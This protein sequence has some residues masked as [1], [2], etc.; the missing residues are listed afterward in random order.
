V[1]ICCAFAESKAIAPTATPN[2]A[3]M[4]SPIGVSVPCPTAVAEDPMA[5]DAPPLTLIQ[6][7]E[8]GNGGPALYYECRRCGAHIVIG[9]EIN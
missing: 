1:H 2:P 7:D 5:V 3:G 6:K 8:A 9:M 4:P